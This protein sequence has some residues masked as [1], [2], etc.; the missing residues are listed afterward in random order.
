MF[1]CTLGS[2]FALTASSLWATVGAK[3]TSNC[4]TE[5]S[6]SSA[7][8]VHSRKWRGEFPKDL[9]EN[10]HL[11]K[12]FH[13]KSPPPTRC[14][15]GG[16]SIILW[17]CNYECMWGNVERLKLKHRWRTSSPFPLERARHLCRPWA[18][19]LCSCEISSSI[20]MI[21]DAADAP[22]KTSHMQQIISV[23]LRGLVGHNHDRAAFRPNLITAA[24]PLWKHWARLFI[25]VRL[26]PKTNKYPWQ[27]Q[28]NKSSMQDLN[29]D[30]PSVLVMEIFQHEE[31]EHIRN[32]DSNI[33][34][35]ISRLLLSSL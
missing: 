31:E 6:I 7:M 18:W 12:L 20:Q 24:Q 23:F 15:L 10:Q 14:N 33:C 25:W 16:F 17:K 19:R 5:M 8:L 32:A 22:T 1:P 3:T 11:S 13:K 28:I 34:T 35:C 4:Q 27:Q 30:G 26:Q 29:S 2:S 9:W 21:K